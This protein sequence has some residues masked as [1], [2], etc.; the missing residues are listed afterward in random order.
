MSH[1]IY[2]D[3]CVMNKAQNILKIILVHINTNLYTYDLLRT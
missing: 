2:S 1:N 3:L